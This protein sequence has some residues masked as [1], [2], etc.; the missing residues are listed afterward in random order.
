LLQFEAAVQMHGLLEH[1]GGHGVGAPG[2]ALGQLDKEE[3]N[4]LHWEDGGD[5]RHFPNHV[6]GPT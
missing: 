4:G 2:N 6:H 1:H 3:A 5:C